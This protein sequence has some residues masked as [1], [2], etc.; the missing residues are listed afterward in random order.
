MNLTSLR[1]NVTVASGATRRTFGQLVTW[2]ADEMLALLP[3]R[4]KEMAQRRERRLLVDVDGA[5]VTFILRDGRGLRALGELNGLPDLATTPPEIDD[6]RQACDGRAIEIAV[7]IPPERALQRTVNLPIAAGRHLSAV[8][9]FE[10]DR[11]TPFKADQ[12]YYGFAVRGRD[13][14]KG[15]L[16]VALT[17]V[18][19]KEADP[20]LESLRGWG[21]EP[22]SLGVREGDD[23]GVNLLPAAHKEAPPTFHLWANRALAAIASALLVAVVALPLVQKMEIASQLE[24]QVA[25]ARGEALQADQ[26]R[27]ELQQLVDEESAIFERRKQRPSGIQVLD[28][29]TRLLPDSAW[30]NRFEMNDARVTIRGEAANASELVK[31]IESSGKFKSAAFEGAMTRDARTERERFTISATAVPMVKP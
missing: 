6:V 18:P 23:V 26:V 30:L 31:L 29:L 4:V 8:L 15:E 22:T 11:Y 1:H 14:G 10:L 27:K 5:R 7:R 20:L 17:L 25:L 12:V 21:L 19:R 3:Q 13:R 28:E 9:A 2:W 16:Q 24:E